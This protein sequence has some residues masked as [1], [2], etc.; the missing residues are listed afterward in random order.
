MKTVPEALNTVKNGSGN[1]IHENWTRRPLYRRKIIRE[2][3]KLK[4]D[5]TSS[6]PPKMSLRAQNMKT[7][8]GALYTAKNGSSSA[9]QKTYTRHP[10]YRRKRIREHKT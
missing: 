9:K 2:C 8:H 5:P 4:P 10:Q 6:I 1:A 3:K 7:I